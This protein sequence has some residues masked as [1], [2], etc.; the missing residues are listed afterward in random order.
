MAVSF[1]PGAL[2]SRGWRGRE[3]IG[4]RKRLLL[5]WTVA[6]LGCDGAGDSAPSPSA[7]PVALPS[8]QKPAQDE[9]EAVAAKLKPLVMDFL[10]A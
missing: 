9:G 7:A 8:A 4:M 6:L 1:R 5:I 2:R 3:G 10:R